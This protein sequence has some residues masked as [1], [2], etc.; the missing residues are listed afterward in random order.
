MSS[1]KGHRMIQSS[2]KSHGRRDRWQTASTRH[3][4]PQSRNKPVPQIEVLEYTKQWSHANGSPPHGGLCFCQMEEAVALVD[5][6]DL[7]THDYPDGE[8]KNQRGHDNSLV[9]V[10]LYPNLT[11]S[12][13]NVTH[14]IRA[15]HIHETDQRWASAETAQIGNCMSLA[16]IICL[17]MSPGIGMKANT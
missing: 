1:E 9:Y 5:A 2:R 15:S 10:R 16:S 12:S 11:L 8:T 14:H 7:E 4:S 3:I 6:N 17:T 13:K